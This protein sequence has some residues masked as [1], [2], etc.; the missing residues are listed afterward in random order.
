FPGLREQADELV[1]AAGRG[2]LVEY[3]SLDSDFHLAILQY[4]DNARLLSL[5]QS[6]RSQTRLFGLSS[7]HERGHL[8]DSAREHHTIMD[9]IEA[10]DAA[11][12]RALV[13]THIEHVL[14][15]WSGPVSEDQAAEV[16][17]P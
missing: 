5:I 3:L 15:E 13:H 8:A 17:S 14:G 1:A 12:A 7:L 4:A 11:G 6:L 9:A 2:D 16:P 10:R